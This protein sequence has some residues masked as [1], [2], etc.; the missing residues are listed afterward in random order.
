VSSIKAV[1]KVLFVAVV[2]IF[3]AFGISKASP[4]CGNLVNGTYSWN[5]PNAWCSD[6]ST[7]IGDP[8]QAA[9]TDGDWDTYGYF[10]AYYSIGHFMITYT[11][12]SGAAND[13]M[14][15][16]K[17]GNGDNNYSIPFECWNSTPDN[18]M[19]RTTT[20]LQLSGTDWITGEC[21]NGTDW[22]VIWKDTSV[23]NAPNIPIAP[24]QYEQAMW[25]DI[26]KDCQ[27]ESSPPAANSTNETSGNSTENT[28]TTTIPENVT[29]ETSETTIQSTATTAPIVTQSSGGG[30][31]G[32]CLAQGD[33]C[34]YSYQ[35]CNNLECLN[36]TCAQNISAGTSTT[37]APIEESSTTSTQ[38]ATVAS[39]S[40]TTTASNSQSQKGGTTGFFVLANPVATG[41][42]IFIV[43][44]VAM[45][46]LYFFGKMS[47]KKPEPAPAP[48]P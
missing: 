26:G 20:M 41:G 6:Q 1:I 2:S 24:K 19:F 45:A 12:P 30:G 7:C 42:I 5:Q 34:F 16:F 18:I 14:W 37:T 13:S 29:N 8:G 25:W 43:I 36:N 48:M 4:L 47:L 17:D 22:I 3:F 40:T 44:L 27:G 28:T 21:Y 9:M 32:G 35:C 10:G 31:G 15:E 23:S 38:A 11:K 46:A 39:E 33:H